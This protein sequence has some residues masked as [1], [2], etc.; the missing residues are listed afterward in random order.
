L[1]QVERDWKERNKGEK[2]E[3]GKGTKHMNEKKKWVMDEH[4]T[5]IIPSSISTGLSQ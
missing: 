1:F 3:R 4:T 5:E 2:T